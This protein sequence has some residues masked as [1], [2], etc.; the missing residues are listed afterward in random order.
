MTATRVA[1]ALAGVVWLAMVLLLWR[2]VFPTTPAP[3]PRRVPRANSSAPTPSVAIVVLGQALH[4]DHMP[5]A[6]MKARVEHAL[7]MWQSVAAPAVVVLSG[8]GKPEDVALYPDVTEARAMRDLLRCAHVVPEDAVLLE[9]ASTNTA[10]NARNSVA[11]LQARGL[12]IDTMYVVTSDWHTAR[13]RVPFEVFVPPSWRLAMAGAPPVSSVRSHRDLALL[14]STMADVAH[15]LGV[16][17]FPSASLLWAAVSRSLAG[18]G[19][20]GVVWTAS[21][22]AP[23]PHALQSSAVAVLA[24]PCVVPRAASA[25]V[26][27][28]VTLDSLPAHACS[29]AH[30]S[31]GLVPSQGS[32]RFRDALTIERLVPLT[33][34]SWIVRVHCDAESS[35]PLSD[36]HAAALAPWN[37]RPFTASRAS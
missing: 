30:V 33:S 14:P 16:E 15:L 20:S 29:L 12:S 11:L 1:L 10:E 2:H 35:A 26:P 13:A 22:G 32:P 23:P 21:A 8:G 6:G 17:R 28:L 34:S 37:C 31:F 24:G 25:P 4:R 5:T 36:A 19:E 9:E 3:P 27:V 18:R 7:R